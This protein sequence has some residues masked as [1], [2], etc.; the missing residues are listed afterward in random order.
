M[1]PVGGE[2]GPASTSRDAPV[3]QADDV[4]EDEVVFG[5]GSGPPDSESGDV[6]PLLERDLRPFLRAV[7]SSLLSLQSLTVLD[8]V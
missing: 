2:R 5:P 6:V 1:A 4:V 3:L 7:S 8:M